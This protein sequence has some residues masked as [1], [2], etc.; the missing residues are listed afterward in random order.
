MAQLR[1]CPPFTRL[2]RL[3]PMAWR[4]FRGR[5]LAGEPRVKPL[6]A[7][8]AQNRPLSEV[9]RELVDLGELHGLF[10]HLSWS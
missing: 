8:R 5:H 6:I 1:Y 9:V 7:S 2:V 3:L 4:P 10:S